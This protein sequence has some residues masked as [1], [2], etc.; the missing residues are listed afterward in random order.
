MSSHSISIV[1]KQSEYPDSKSKVKEILDWL[2]S[3]N[4]IK[5]SISDCIL[6]SENGY[7][8]SEGARDITN[9]NVYLPFDLITNGLEITTKR[10]IFHT[11]QNGI[12]ECICPN[13]KENIASD[14]WDFLDDWF[15]HKSNNLTC[16]HC[17][18]E[19][20]INNYSFEPQWGFS[21]IG[22]TF[23]NWPELKEDFIEEF[24][25]RLGVEICI[26]NT[27]I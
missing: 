7:A 25:E 11:G 15:E 8:I 4:I 17:D 27:R 22:F 14:V 13:C 12:D 6:A 10:Q 5:P 9:Y 19:T 18:Q 24:Q 1:P 16:T 20:E 3:K 2:V 23:W 26:V 21:N